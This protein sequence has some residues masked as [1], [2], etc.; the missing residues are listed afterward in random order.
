MRKLIMICP[1][2]GFSHEFELGPFGLAMGGFNCQ[3]GTDMEFTVYG[4][5]IILPEDLY[6]LKPKEQN[7][8]H[9]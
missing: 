2:C 6:K 1:D 7:D 4:G 5:P 8:K 9:N 3:C